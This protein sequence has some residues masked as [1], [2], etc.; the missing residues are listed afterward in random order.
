MNPSTLA[1][2]FLFFYTSDTY[3]PLLEHMAKMDFQPHIT[4]KQN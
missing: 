3:I 1:N 4:Q 2:S